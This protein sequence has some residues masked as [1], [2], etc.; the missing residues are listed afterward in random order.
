MDRAFERYAVEEGN[1]I[2]KGHRYGR[3]GFPLSGVSCQKSVFGRFV[4]MPHWAGVH[5]TGWTVSTTALS[6]VQSA[7]IGKNSP[8]FST[9]Q[10][11]IQKPHGLNFISSYINNLIV[12]ILV[13]FKGK[14]A[15]WLLHTIADYKC[16]YFVLLATQFYWFRW[17]ASGLFLDYP[18]SL[19]Q[20]RVAQTTPLCTPEL[21]SV[22]KENTT[23]LRWTELCFLIYWPGKTVITQH[24]L[25]IQNCRSIMMNQN[26]EPSTIITLLF[27]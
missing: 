3:W 17:F 5:S 26:D 9:L 12:F 19:A 7:T 1:R 21:P 20:K 18:R 27:Y 8:F 25:N 11:H 15:G 16:I 4:T 2:E 14:V 22:K 24:Q 6:F 10:V 13:K 23:F